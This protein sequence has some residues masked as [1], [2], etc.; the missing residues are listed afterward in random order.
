MS[1]DVQ[2][3]KKWHQ[4]NRVGNCTTDRAA[5]PCETLSAAREV[6]ALR[7]IVNELIGALLPL[8]Q[9]LEREDRFNERLGIE[10]WGDDEE[11]LATRQRNGTLRRVLTLAGER[12]LIEATA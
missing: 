12:G 1:I 6:E 11:F 3:I 10:R 7:E 8:A 5:W 2:T 4:R 9:M